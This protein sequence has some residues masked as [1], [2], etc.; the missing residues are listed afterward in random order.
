MVFIGLSRTD[1]IMSVSEKY[2]NICWNILD[3]KT[4][5]E[6]WISL[7]WIGSIVD[8]QDKVHYAD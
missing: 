2:R 3:T 4:D 8:I 6:D 7:D 1:T 5:R